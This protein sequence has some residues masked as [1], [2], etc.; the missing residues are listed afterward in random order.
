MR[1][2]TLDKEQYT[3]IIS[4]LYKG[5]RIDRSHQIKANPA[6]ATALQISA[7]T[8]MLMTDIL[9]LKRNDIKWNDEKKEYYIDILKKGTGNIE[10]ILIPESVVAMIDAYREEN[11]LTRDDPLFTTTRQNMQIILKRVIDYYGYK[12]INVDSFRKYF[13]AKVY[14]ESGD[15]HLTAK[16]L[17]HKRIGV[18]KRY[19]NM[20]DKELERM[21]TIRKFKD[22]KAGNG[23]QFA[24]IKETEGKY[25]ASGIVYYYPTNAPEK[26]FEVVDD[27]NVHFGY[28]HFDGS[29]LYDNSNRAIFEII[30][31]LD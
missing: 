5:V 2:S 6:I 26:R 7:N 16:L 31:P 24:Y 13:G 9:N 11:D 19:L 25:P 10:K 22:H 15:I 8:G 4:G 29:L 20:K 28:A 12:K 27:H 17:N 1:V 3:N 14:L 21:N 18:T 23:V 30:E